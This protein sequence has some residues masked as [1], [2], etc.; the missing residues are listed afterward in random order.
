MMQR[1][2]GIGAEI[3]FEINILYS[4]TSSAN[5]VNSFHSMND[6]TNANNPNDNGKVRWSVWKT[7]KEILNL[8]ACVV[9][10]RMQLP[11]S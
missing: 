6:L 8:H 4:N 2:F 7:A 9:S 10:M 5:R 3:E 1:E 11:I